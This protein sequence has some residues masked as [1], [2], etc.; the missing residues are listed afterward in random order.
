MGMI[1][2]VYTEDVFKEFI[3]PSINNADYSLVLHKGIFG[4][5]KNLE[6]KLENINERWRIK[7]NKEYSIYR[8]NKKY[9]GEFLIN[10][11]Y[12]SI[13]TRESRLIKLTVHQVSSAFRPYTKYSL[14]NL[15]CI[16]IGKNEENDIQYDYQGMVSKQHAVLKWEDAGWIIQNKGQNKLYVNSS[17]V[18]GECRLKFGD[19]INILG[20]HCT[21]LGEVLAIDEEG[22]TITVNKNVLTTYIPEKSAKS[23]NADAIQEAGKKN[24]HRS[25]RK[26]EKIEIGE[27]EIEGPP[28]LA[29]GRKQPLY[30]TIG[31]S[32]TMSLPMLLGCLL[33]IYSSRISGGT[34]GL[35]MYSGLIMSISSAMIGVLW[36]ILNIRYQK[37]MEREEEL[38]RF[39]AYSEYLFKRTEEIKTK[40]QKNTK[41][42]HAIYPDAK[43]CTSYRYGSH[44]LWNRNE[45][46]EDFLTYRLGIGEQPFQV[47]IHVPKEKFTLIEDSL[48]D[49]PKFIKDNYETLYEVPVG[50]DLKKHRLVGIIG[51]KEKRGAFEIVKAL[52]VQI[53]ANNCYTDVRM[54]YI[55]D[56]HEATDFTQWEFAKWFPHVW[57]EDGK[58]RYIAANK[59]EASDVFYELT[60]ILRQR[61]EEKQ[62]G[63]GIKP[64]IILF[65]ENSEWLNEELISRYI[66]DPAFDCGISTLILAEEYADLPNSCDYM[67]QND[68]KF[69]GIYS[70]FPQK[71][72]KKT[73]KFDIVE[74]EELLHFA[75]ELSD[76]EVQET[77]S[78]G[79]VPSQLTFFDMY[80]IRKPEELQIEERWLKNRTYENIKGLIGQKAGGVP[81]FLDMHEKYH[82]PHGLVAG[83]TGSGK[84]ETLQTY[85]M[86]LAV[87]YS[88]DD[89]GFFVIDYK[90]GGMAN[91]FDGLP[92][93]IGQ[94]SNLSGNQVN[95]AMVAIK[96]ENR[97]RQRIFNEYGVN[98]INLYTKLYKNKEASDPIPHL[99]I[100]I[101]EF[102]EL[103]KEEPEF[104]KELISVAQVGR[105]LGVHLILA[106]QKPSGTVDDNIW[107]NAKFR[108]CLRVQDKQDSQD[109]LH[110]P[111]AA[112][113][114]QAGRAYLQ[115]GNDEVYELF[116][117]GWSGAPY[118]E[119]IQEGR[120]E[121][122]ALITN[123]GKE[124]I[125]GNYYKVQS[126]EK[127]IYQWLVSIET[128][129]REALVFCET[130]LEECVQYRNKMQEVIEHLYL[131]LEKQEKAY[132]KSYYN[133]LRLED[134]IKLYKKAEGQEIDAV[135]WMMEY[136]AK[137]N[138]R[139]PQ[140]KEKTQLDAVKE[141]L[142]TV[143]EKN[144]YWYKQKLWMPVLAEKIFLDEFQEYRDTAFQNGKW[145]ALQ[146]QWSLEVVIGKVD[147]PHNQAQM[148]LLLNFGEKG[149]LAV[150]G[151]IVSGKSTFLQT[152][153]Y[154]MTHK[155]TPNEINLYILDFSS[156]M[157]SSFENLVHVG[158]MMYE[159]DIDRIAKF[160]NMMKGV[161]EE[162]KKL[163]RGGNYSQYIQSH[164]MVMPA[165]FIVIDNYSVFREKT[166][167]RY[168]SI[169]TT[170]SK[171]GVNQGIYMILTASGFG[172]NEIPNRVGENIK[173][174]VCLEM[175]DKYAYADALHTMKFSILPE[176]NV[177]GRGLVSYGNQIL[178]FQTALAL[179]A[180]DD[181]QRMERIASEC[182]IL[183]E[184]WTGKKARKI[185]EIP[186]KPIWSEFQKLDETRDMVRSSRY[187][188]TAYKESNASV[189][190]IDLLKTYCYLITGT[191]RTGKKNYMKVMIQASL[192]KQAKICVMDGTGQDF[193]SYSIDSAIDYVRNE[194]E[195]FK[196]F[197]Q[198]SP[199]FQN[200][201]QVKNQMIGEDNDEEEIFEIQSRE[202]P[203]FIFINDL[204]WFLDTVYHS[205]YQMSGFLETI[206][207]KGSLHH[208][209]FI[210]I[211]ETEK[212]S[213]A[214]GY[215]AFHYFTGYHTGIHFGGKVS[216]HPYFSWEELSFSEREKAEKPGIGMPA[217]QISEEWEGKVVV[218]LARR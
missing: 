182:N 147:D 171:E 176:A 66:F 140:M 186:K 206:W 58:I 105:S 10:E 23:F 18:S 157:L 196:F 6:L 214:A 99:F 194:E 160:F 132:S 91:L 43:S 187:L 21:F 202:K 156:K 48:N 14:K 75:R 29:N 11:D 172:T 35:F 56:E 178:E 192:L 106:T 109:M 125:V 69:Q 55:Y 19:F 52:S 199:V 5:R 163:F 25:P 209:Y 53:A 31:P 45:R 137:E 64:Y 87:N 200:R 8:N 205:K 13:S 128:C 159:T 218:P 7:E 83:T 129:L 9:T 183:N 168:D 95:R 211:L 119:K 173:N 138:I 74:K 84:S 118:D 115:V 181:Y 215:Q 120:A 65:V 20:L 101:D 142:A 170:L 4:L 44:L 60:K 212:Y 180:R 217:V 76:V 37:K 71:E 33:M 12:L 93:M 110:K 190:G 208:I 32:F 155:Y 130:S 123:T 144:G 28:A 198:L 2:A 47:K 185:P 184:A 90:G 59:E 165:I 38:H 27:I 107:S 149:S 46:H 80:H 63:I 145:K 133:S 103:K 216:T 193:E 40:Y 207:K 68:E 131:S 189:F 85:M 73:I 114:T 148:P 169:L 112:Y 188:P 104:M 203:V 15:K 146:N 136:A 51:G 151:G 49:T 108:L 201:N 150:C 143:A 121:T 179:R 177:K 124:D 61:V 204:I 127:G 3:L 135:K 153:V 77:E 30:L 175:A 116:Q 62:N 50:V 195:I 111:D 70:V 139:L 34:S 24:F 17:V 94:I 22:K 96:S 122:V 113:I 1:V 26:V 54:A 152:L 57:S 89:I 117:S 67:I 154:A 72:E 197:E 16:T 134:Y 191:E 141:Y 78:G 100:V 92:H 42:L 161:L 98:N 41:A 39:D 158:G 102:A 86:S 97:R 166:K 36:A 213:F 174:V 164:G 81:C 167:E 79:E 126:K 82:G 162:R 88:P 210:G